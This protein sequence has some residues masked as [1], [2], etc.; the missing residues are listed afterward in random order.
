MRP[1]SSLLFLWFLATPLAAQQP[2]AIRSGDLS[3]EIADSTFSALA[4]SV[5]A[6]G[7]SVCTGASPIREKGGPKVRCHP[8][9][10]FSDWTQDLSLQIV[11]V[12]PAGGGATV[13]RLSP[14]SL[15]LAGR[16]PFNTAC[17]TWRYWLTLDPR[18]KQH[19]ARAVLRPDADDV[20]S[21]EVHGDLPMA[22]VLHLEAVGGG[23]RYDMPLTLHLDL[24]GRW[25]AIPLPLADGILKR[26]ASNLMLFAEPPGK[27]GGRWAARRECTGLSPFVGEICLS[28]SRSLLKILN[29]NP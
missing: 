27:P 24:A 19:I 8:P 28:A 20:L 2:V 3:L 12:L 15:R 23:S 11:E 21:G 18:V 9:D 5:P 1:R 25:T 13:V 7:A 16:R 4:I 26:T 29:V 14:R 22:A 17:G 10:L 6:L